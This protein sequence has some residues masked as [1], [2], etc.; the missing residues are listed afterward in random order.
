[1]A[2][3]YL[4]ANFNSFFGRLNPGTSFEATASSLYN[5]IKGLIED[6]RGL[7]AG[8]SP[9]CFLQSSYR[10]QTAIYLDQRR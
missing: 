8:L 9:T 7:A 10:Q 6:R 5:T 1:M 4:S 3:H 2:I